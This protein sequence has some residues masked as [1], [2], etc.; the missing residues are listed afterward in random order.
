LLSRCNYLI[1]HSTILQ[2]S[3]VT[4][5][6]S[7]IK[8]QISTSTPKGKTPTLVS[9]TN[10]KSTLSDEQL[11]AQA[12]NSASSNGGASVEC[13][14]CSPRRTRCRDSHVRGAG[15]AFGRSIGYC[16]QRVAICN[17][18]KWC[19]RFCFNSVCRFNPKESMS[20]PKK[21]N[22]TTTA[23]T[24]ATTVE[25]ERDRRHSDIFSSTFSRRKQQLQAHHDERSRNI[26]RQ[27]FANHRRFVKH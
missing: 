27:S 6:Y 25:R 23:T 11:P 1:V 18:L 13:A 2:L 19:V 26:G 12:S 16:C 20:M 17:Q 14:L 15:A 7:I 5:T 10:K 24:T 9:P 4:I 3:P 22:T 21:F 8:S